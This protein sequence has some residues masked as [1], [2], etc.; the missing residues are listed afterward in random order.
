MDKKMISDYAVRIAFIII[1]VVIVILDTCYLSNK[2]R[3]KKSLKKED[4]IYL[5]VS[6]PEKYSKTE[7]DVLIEELEYY[8]K[9]DI[10][11]VEFKNNEVNYKLKRRN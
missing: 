11:N 8:K 3:I 2:Q 9:Y 1:I 5:Y 7:T 10:I 6:F 4:E